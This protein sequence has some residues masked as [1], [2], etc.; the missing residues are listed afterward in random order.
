MLGI[1]GQYP[2]VKAQTYAAASSFPLL[3]LLLPPPSFPT[4]R[5]RLSGSGVEQFCFANEPPGDAKAAGVGG[6]GPTFVLSMAT[7]QGPSPLGLPAGCTVLTSTPL[8]AS[9]TPKACVSPRLGGRF[10]PSN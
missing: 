6:P 7:P 10:L 1:W 2:D 9:P 8:S 4:P 5:S 3:F